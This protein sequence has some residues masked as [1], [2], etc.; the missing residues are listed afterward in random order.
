MIKYNYS[1]LNHNTFGFDVK[2]ERFFDYHTEREL[3]DFL[4]D[5]KNL[6]IPVFHIGSG[7]NLLFVNDFNGTI[8][9]SSIKSVKIE[10]QTSDNVFVKVSSGVVM[11]DFCREMTEKN[12]GGVENLSLIYGEVG[13]CAVQNIGAY[14]VEIKDV[15]SK[16]EALEISTQKKRIFDV[17]EC[18]YAYRDSIFKNELKD[19]FIITSVLFCLTKNPKPNL[20]YYALKQEFENQPTPNIKEVREAVI[21]I[22]KS[23]LP[24]TNIYG[25]AGSFFKNPYCHTAHFETLKKSYPNIPYYFVNKDVIK[26][27]AAWLIEQCGFKGKR[28]GNVGTYQTQPLVLV[29]YG[30]ALPSEIINLAKD[31]QFAV[32][33]K[34]KIEL[35]REVI[36]VLQ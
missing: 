36:Y 6:D 16:V 28:T 18:N 15:I 2:A 7:S 9:H 13:A 17:S 10:S 20:E 11:D 22:R 26:L 27:S 35:E 5:K 4:S 23:K 14:G 1:L 31:I 29:N 32:F 3:I 19:R 33:E 8:L 24:D 21:K 34:F 12:F 25:N 30:G